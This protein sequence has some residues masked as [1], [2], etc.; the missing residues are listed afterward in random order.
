[1]HGRTTILDAD[2]FL[3][4]FVPQPT[5]GPGVAP[6]KKPASLFKR[7][8][9]PKNESV[10]YKELPKRLKRGFPG[11]MY[12]FVATPYKADRNTT[13]LLSPDCGMYPRPHVPR[14]HKGQ[15]RDTFLATNWAHIEL[16]IECKSNGSGDPFDDKQPNGE[17]KTAKR[18]DALGQILS[19]AELVLEY[20]QRTHLFMLVFFG[21]Y[22]RIVRF[23]RSGIFATQKMDYLL[24][25]RLL[26]EFIW[27]YVQLS[28]EDRGY[29]TTV[30][31]IDQNSELAG[32]MRQRRD[33]LEKAQPDHYLTA[34]WT[35]ALDSRRPWWKVKVEDDITKKDLW[36]VVGK[37][38]F[39]AP[40]VR[41]RG[42]RGYVALPLKIGEDGEQLGEKFVYLKDAWR[43]VAEGIMPEGTT[44]K[45]LN[46][47]KDVP[48]IPTLLSHGDV[49]GQSTRSPVVWELLHPGKTCPLKQHQHYRSVVAEV[50]KPLSSFKDSYQLVKAVYHCALAHRAAY[51]HGYIHRDISAGNILLYPNKN[52]HWCGLLNDWELAKDRNRELIPRQLERTGTWQFLSVNILDDPGSVVV[53]ADE[54]ESMFHVVIYYAVRFLHHNIT[55]NNVGQFLHDYFD[56][57]AP[58]HG[59]KRCGPSKRLA[60][61]M[62]RISLVNYHGRYGTGGTKLR[63]LR[64]PEDRAPAGEASQHPLNDIVSTLL[65]WFKAHYDHDLDEEETDERAPPA[66]DQPS[67]PDSLCRTLDD[68]FL[69]A[70]ASGDSDEEN[71][72]AAAPSA[73]PIDTD[74]FRQAEKLRAEKERQLALN[75]EN[76]DAFIEL[77]R[78]ALQHAK[79]WPTSEKTKDQRNRDF[80]PKLEP[81]SD[82]GEEEEAADEDEDDG[83]DNDTDDDEEGERY[84]PEN[85]DDEIDPE[86]TAN[87]YDLVVEVEDDEDKGHMEGG[88]EGQEVGGCDDDSSASMHDSEGFPNTRDGMHVDDPAPRSSVRRSERVRMKRKAEEPEDAGSGKRSRQG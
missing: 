67:S 18:R 30:L 76:H 53:I 85:T 46:D 37:P 71:A 12:G 80:V 27:R 32:K 61:W 62:G 86:D 82:D 48:F 1:M 72:G 56:D 51:K 19:Y 65:S 73:K 36:Y 64:P 9:K 63:F 6:L 41:G 70:M 24:N 59:G 31:R 35:E 74:S 49:T 75:L 55:A 17:P 52:G 11:T 57:Y 10:L 44:L 20:Q 84:Q 47:Y 45:T 77:L 26:I 29:D 34:L 4:H 7:M 2:K 33:D 60:M 88:V 8:K 81:N 5:T 38:N 40:G 66:E 39:Q 87:D 42:T 28:P 14:R 50:G 22:Y 43:V 15:R 13:S 23:D 3:Q 16:P 79:A 83:A 58:H 68:E 25:D 21:K 54:L 69:D 78:Q